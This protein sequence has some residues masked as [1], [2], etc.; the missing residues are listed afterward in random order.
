LKDHK[1]KFE[2][3]SNSNSGSFQSWSNNIFGAK[4]RKKY[5]ANVNSLWVFGH[6][7]PNTKTAVE[8]KLVP[9]CQLNFGRVTMA[10][11]KRQ[12]CGSGDFIEIT[13]GKG[14]VSKI[15]CINKKPIVIK[16]QCPMY[17]N[18]VSDANRVVGK[19]V[20]FNWKVLGTGTGNQNCGLKEEYVVNS[21]VWTVNIGT[22]QFWK[23]NGKRPCIGRRCKGKAALLKQIPSNTECGT[24]IRTSREHWIECD[25]HSGTNFG[26]HVPQN[27]NCEKHYVGF[28]DGMNGSDGVTKNVVC[29][30][31]A[32][33]R[34]VFR[35]SNNALSIKLVVG[36]L[37]PREKNMVIYGGFAGCEMQGEYIRPVLGW[38]VGRNTSSSVEDEETS[39]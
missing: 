11:I 24:V 12:K 13:N 20:A 34:S 35:S 1:Y 3:D 6:N 9:Q 8:Q 27:P 33:T 28:Y 17:V 25:T 38:A 39:S 15:L 5:P 26:Y 21:N 30:R 23:G 18:F 22:S 29:G 10:S 16:E 36:A 7:S 2:S 4:H 14:E 19:P 31:N 37:L 32:R